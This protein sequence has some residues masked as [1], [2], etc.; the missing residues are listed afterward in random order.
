MTRAVKM[1]LFFF[2]MLRS[3]DNPRELE[4]FGF[5]FTGTVLSR[6]DE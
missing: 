1:F 4:L 2:V 6:V 5:A 3:R